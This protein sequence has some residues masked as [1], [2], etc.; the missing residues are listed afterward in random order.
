M[1]NNLKLILLLLLI[2]TVVV[3]VLLCSS[4]PNTKPSP[5]AGSVSYEYTET[6]GGIRITNVRG[7]SEQIII[8]D[9]IDG[10]KVVEIGNSAFEGKKIIKTVVLPGSLIKV[11]YR[12]FAD[13]T[14][15]KTVT[16]N[17]GLTMIEA[18]AFSGCD[19]LVD[20]ILPKSVKYKSATAFEVGQAVSQSEESAFVREPEESQEQDN[21]V[22]EPEESKAEE[23]KVEESITGHE[24][25][26]SEVFE[27]SEPDVSEPIKQSTK[28]TEN[29]FFV[30]YQSDPIYASHP[31]G[32][33]TVGSH[34]CG[35]STMSVIIKNLTGADVNPVTMSDWSYEKGYYAKGVGSYH[36]LIPAAAKNWGIKSEAYYTYNKQF[37][38]EQLESGKL[39]LVIM[40]PGTFTRSGHYMILRGFDSDGKLIIADTQSP[41]RTSQTWDFDLIYSE[42]KKG[43]PLWVFSR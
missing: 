16:F 37:I 22:S 25:E 11:G 36:A 43:S 42:L 21:I 15:L 23:S 30:M 32:Y 1:K 5:T 12:A 38:R 20:Y 31:Y 39:M 3:A 4:A 18:E 33:E 35:P 26:V 29:D 19:N 24:S 34:G 13:C 6:N 41:V 40:G 10:K 14:S 8:P 2:L 17:D 28:F 9:L 7:E 27:T